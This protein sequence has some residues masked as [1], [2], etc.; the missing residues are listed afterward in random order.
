MDVA[1]LDEHVLDVDAT[2]ERPEG[3]ELGRRVEA[4]PE[5]VREVEVAAEGRGRDTRCELHDAPGVE[6]PLE[7]ERHSALRGDRA[8]GC[9]RVGAAVEVLVRAELGVQEEREEHDVGAELVG[10]PDGESD[11]LRGRLGGVP[12]AGRDATV[13]VLAEHERMDLDRGRRGPPPEE[14]DVASG[15][16]AKLRP[17]RAQLDAGEPELACLCDDVADRERRVHQ[18][19]LHRSASLRRCLAN[20]LCIN[21]K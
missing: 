1:G 3:A 12:I 11:V 6:E 18:R 20:L 8:E 9:E 10:K 21:N 19:D 14:P 13:V 5:G 7:A 2:H 16:R 17:R 15:R 4:A